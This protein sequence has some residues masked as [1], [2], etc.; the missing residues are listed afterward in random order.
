MQSRSKGSLLQAAT[1]ST[2]PIP[3]SLC[4]AKGFGLCASTATELNESYVQQSSARLSADVLTQVPTVHAWTAVSGG[5][6][7]SLTS[8]QLSDMS[9]R[10]G[11]RIASSGLKLCEERLERRDIMQKGHS[12]G[13]HSRRRARENGKQ[14]LKLCEKPLQTRDNMQKGHSTVLVPRCLLPVS[15]FF[16]P[17]SVQKRAVR[18][19]WLKAAGLGQPARPSRGH[20]PRAGH[21]LLPAATGGASS[22]TQAQWRA[23]PPRSG[24]P[25]SVA[26]IRCGRRVA[27]RGQRGVRDGQPGGA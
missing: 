19:A 21:R 17:F 23:G 26:A 11:Q 18:R 22:R 15:F 7:P 5:A 16:T 12:T 24:S 27:P 3:L 9:R 25:T 10:A 2:G 13:A 20:R 8:I 14:W 6:P 1:V 4:T